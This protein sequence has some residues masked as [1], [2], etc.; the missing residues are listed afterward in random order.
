M[1]KAIL[2]VVLLFAA[3]VPSVSQDAFSI[4]HGPY[5]QALE[6]AGVTIVWTT[7]RKAVSWVELAPDDSTHFYLEERP[8][9]FASEGGFKTVSTLHSV[10]LENLKP[11]T[12]YRYRVYSREVL[13]HK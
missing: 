6:E 13:S 8:G 10:R 1:K 2:S 11:G 12:T 4:T 7:N 5:L 3:A 9:F